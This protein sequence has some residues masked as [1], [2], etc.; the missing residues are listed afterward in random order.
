MELYNNDPR[1]KRPRH[2]SQDP[3]DPR[4]LAK[5]YTTDELIDERNLLKKASESYAHIDEALRIK[6]GV[7]I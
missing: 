7:K 5:S 2:P 4:F 3:N 1:Y 6:I